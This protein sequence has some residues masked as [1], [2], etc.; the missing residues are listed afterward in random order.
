MMYRLI[1]QPEAEADIE[2]ASLWYEQQTEGL[3]RELVMAVNEGL[4]S[5]QDYPNSYQ[6]VHRQV[7]RL[8][9]KRFPYQLFYLLTEDAI[10]VF[11]CFHTS[12][13]PMLWKKRL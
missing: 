5:I 6:E 8:I 13:N 3:G 9:L 12:R 1:V 11:G 2:E 10:I 7:R 4:R